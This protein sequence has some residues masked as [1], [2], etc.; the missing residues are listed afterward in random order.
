MYFM[1]EGSFFMISLRTLTRHKD[2]ELITYDDGT[3][4]FMRT[5]AGEFRPHYA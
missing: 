4:P 2:A 3:G 5:D 1:Y